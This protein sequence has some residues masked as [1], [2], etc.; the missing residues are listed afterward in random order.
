MLK[1]TAAI[2]LSLFIC[3]SGFTS[4]VACTPTSCRN[5]ASCVLRQNALSKL[6]SSV[7]ACN[8]GFASVTRS[9]TPVSYQ[10]VLQPCYTPSS[11][12]VL[13]CDAKEYSLCKDSKCIC[14]DKYFAN[15]TSG[16]CE[17][18]ESYT[19]EF[20]ISEYFA[21]P[22]EYCK[23]GN[24]CL[25]GLDCKDFT[26]KCPSPCTYDSEEEVCDCGVI[27]RPDIIGPIITGVILG[28]LIVACW[29]YKIYST[30]DF[31]RE[32]R[33][34]GIPLPPDGDADVIIIS[35]SPGPVTISQGVNYPAMKPPYAAP[36]FHPP[37]AMQNSSLM[38]PPRYPPFQQTSAY[39][40]QTGGYFPNA[41]P[42]QAQA[43]EFQYPRPPVPGPGS[44]FQNSRRPSIQPPPYED[45]VQQDSQPSKQRE[46][47]TEACSQP[48]GEKGE[49]EEEEEEKTP[50]PPASAESADAV[51]RQAMSGHG[52]HGGSSVGRFPDIT[53]D[54]SV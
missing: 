8:N 15:I 23:T 33:K 11:G 12:P 19:K 10:R 48:K 16:N 38:Y 54:V 35:S 20:N 47:S 50:L 53:P 24:H 37:M 28:L 29:T 45:V 27:E 3:S 7:C 4:T 1:A 6:N 34:M 26:C 51:S 18:M 44:E 39:S 5:N 21:R 31:Y 52:A 36:P 46:A 2:L 42:G 49:E 9:C 17:P 32:A 14:F 40:S 43:A 22:G 25:A 30:V 41:Y 13:L